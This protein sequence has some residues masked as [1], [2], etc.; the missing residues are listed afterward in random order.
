[1]TTLSLYLIAICS[2]L[3]VLGL[4]YLF[5]SVIPSIRFKKYFA[6]NPSLQ[7]GQSEHK[8]D[9][10]LRGSLLLEMLESKRD[11]KGVLITSVRFSVKEF[12]IRNFDKLY[13][14]AQ[15]SLGQK[16]SVALYIGRKHLHLL[17]NKRVRLDLKGYVVLK[18]NQ[19]ARV[20]ATYML[21]VQTINLPQTSFAADLGLR[22]D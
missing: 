9:H 18:D 13:L 19:R 3:V 15:G 4:W 7:W 17:Q 21:D 11:A 12:H 10:L 2:I 1:M 22:V 5:G 8:Q 6:L 14:D 16:L 20:K